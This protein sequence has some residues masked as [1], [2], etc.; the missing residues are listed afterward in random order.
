MLIS[1][2]SNKKKAEKVVQKPV[3]KKNKGNITSK[4]DL[5]P[6][7]DLNDETP[8]EYMPLNKKKEDTKKEAADSD[9]FDEVDLSDGEEESTEDSK[10]EKKEDSEDFEDLDL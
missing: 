10:E 5:I 1:R 8:L 7:E 9:D 4:V 2:N 6:E 3:K